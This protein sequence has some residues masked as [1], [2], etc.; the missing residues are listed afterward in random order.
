MLASKQKRQCEVREW[1]ESQL[2]A[3]SVGIF[4]LTVEALVC[5]AGDRTWLGEDAWLLLYDRYSKQRS[6]HALG[7]SKIQAVLR[8]AGRQHLSARRSW[9]SCLTIVKH[10]RVPCSL[11]YG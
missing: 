10:V 8:K 9:Q 6:L 4:N 1:N 5:K 11:S 7:V 2:K 3:L